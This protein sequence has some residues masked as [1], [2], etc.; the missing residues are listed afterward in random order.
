MA[1]I[2][3]VEREPAVQPDFDDE[4]IE[5][6]KV[7]VPSPNISLQAILEQEGHAV[8]NIPPVV[9]LGS[10]TYPGVLFASASFQQDLMVYD[11]ED[12]HEKQIQHALHLMNRQR[13]PSIVVTNGEDFAILPKKGITVPRTYNPFRLAKIYIPALLNSGYSSFV[14]R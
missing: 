4:G 8:I 2:A 5:I 9:M 3:I 14:W 10:Q 13:F 12:V 11:T 7:E 1:R 6:G